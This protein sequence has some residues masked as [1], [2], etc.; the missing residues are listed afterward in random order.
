MDNVN[1]PV[2]EA[3]QIIL[4]MEYMGPIGLSFSGLVVWVNKPYAVKQ[5]PKDV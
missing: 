1:E 5:D 4:T 2:V 3:A